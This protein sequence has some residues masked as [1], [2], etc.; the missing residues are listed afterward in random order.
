MFLYSAAKG[1]LLGTFFSGERDLGGVFEVD[2]RRPR[3]AIGI[4]EIKYSD[5][6]FR[7]YL[8]KKIDMIQIEIAP[9]PTIM[10]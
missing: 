8:A 1:V 10:R 4:H 7:W 6:I 9:R 5:T 3:M 2:M